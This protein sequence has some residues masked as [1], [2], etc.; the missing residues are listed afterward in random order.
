MSEAVSSENFCWLTTPLFFPT[1]PGEYK[2]YAKFADEHIEGSPF[3]CKVTGEGTK[4][5]TISVGATSD[6]RSDHYRNSI[7]LTF[8]TFHNQGLV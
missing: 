3:T 1:A 8:H 2:I 5:K 6:L 7:L 4:R